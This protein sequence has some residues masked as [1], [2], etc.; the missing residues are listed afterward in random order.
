MTRR[1]NSAIEIP[2]C[3]DW[4][5]LKTL[6]TSCCCC[7]RCVP[8]SVREYERKIEGIDDDL[9]RS[10]DIISYVKKL[11]MH[12]LALSVLLS[13]T[14]REVSGFLCDKRDVKHLRE[15]R[16]VDKRGAYKDHHNSR[17][18]YS[19]EDV[20]QKEIIFIAFVRKYIELK[21]RDEKEKSLR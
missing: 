11:R 8:K 7:S 19:I 10:L 20:S 14:E 6:L 21:D 17:F 18:W 4:H 1:N 13:H 9:D 15:E 5:H 12:G 2:E 16:T 3:F